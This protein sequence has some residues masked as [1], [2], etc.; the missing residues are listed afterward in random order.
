MRRAMLML[1]ALL[2]AALLPLPPAGA[3]D[4]AA[5]EY[6]TQALP[7][8]RLAGQ[9]E[10]R[11]LLLPIYHAQLWVG[12]GGYR[13]QAP[14][15]APLVLV[16]RY[17]RDLNGRRIA[18]ASADQMAHIGAGSAGQRQAWLERM[19]TIFPDVRSGDTLAGLYTP[20]QG[21]RFYLN[22][23]PLADWPDADFARAFFAIWLSPR[24][25]AAGLRSALL[26]DAAA[27]P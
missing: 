10:Y 24:T 5:P 21:A 3:Q 26:Q 22:G 13:P 19:R 27:A 15:A 14:E 8:A 25:S 20:G 17:A 23:K 18:A 7:G 1:P 12:A 2:L 16:L 11:W 9:G 6:I 4:G